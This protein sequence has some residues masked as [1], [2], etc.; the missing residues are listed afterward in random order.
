MAK[1]P[2]VSCRL[3]V[4]GCQKSSFELTTDNWQ[5]ATE[6]SVHHRDRAA[7]LVEADAALFGADDGVFDA[8]AEVAF[9][10]DTGFVAEDH[11]DREGHLVAADQ[12][13]FLVDVETETVSD[14]VEE[15]RSVARLGDDRPR[16]LVEALAGNAGFDGFQRRLVGAEDDVVDAAELVGRFADEDGAGDVGLVA[17]EGSTPVEDDDV[18]LLDDA[19]A[20]VV[21]RRGA[22]GTAG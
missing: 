21:V 3:P 10:V 17:V 13:R 11:P 1:L 6:D 7:R 15:L 12:I 16:H 19:V 8:D 4:A 22:V 18:A 14:T 9:Q 20:G 2:V 5:P